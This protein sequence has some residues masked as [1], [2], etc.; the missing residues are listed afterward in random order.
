MSVLFDSEREREMVVLA[1]IYTETL[2]VDSLGFMCIFK[3]CVC[4]F[5][6]S[7][8]TE[9][10]QVNLYFGGVFLCNNPCVLCRHFACVCV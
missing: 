8:Y 5:I 6:K 3:L 4:V 1:I 10:L 7:V 9:Q 2:G